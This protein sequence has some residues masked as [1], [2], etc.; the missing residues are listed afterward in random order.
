MVWV[1][2]GRCPK[3]SCHSRINCLPLLHFCQGSKDC[4]DD[5]FWTLLQ[6][7][8]MAWK[9]DTSH[10]NKFRVRSTDVASPSRATK[11]GLASDPYTS[12]C[13]LLRL[14]NILVFTH[15]END[16]VC[17]FTTSVFCKYG[18]HWTYQVWVLWWLPGS[19]VVQRSPPHCSQPS[20]PPLPLHGTVRSD[21]YEHFRIL[22]LMSS[23]FKQPHSGVVTHG[24]VG[25]A[26][27][28]KMNTAQATSLWWSWAEG[29]AVMDTSS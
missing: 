8:L 17:Q 7:F 12:G 13:L 10:Q 18:C 9:T 25:D 22:E 24:T 15:R 3:P 28:N 21:Y 16:S 2:G 20:P 5:Q 14:V 4:S 23:E 6:G 27:V 26:G 29:R 11:L 19:Q 1:W